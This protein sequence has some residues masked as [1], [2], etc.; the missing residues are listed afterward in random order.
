ML[1][2]SLLLLIFLSDNLRAEDPFQ[3]SQRDQQF[4]LS[5]S[6]KSLDPVDLDGF[7]SELSHP[8]TASFGKKLFFDRRLS[9]NGAIACGSCHIP[10]N[11]F[12]DRLPQG[13]G[14]GQT[15]RNTPSVLLAKYSPWQTWDGR[16]DSLWSQALEPLE[17]PLEHGTS[18]QQV[19]EVIKT[20]YLDTY[21]SIFG[22]IEDSERGVDRAFAN[23]G[24]ALMAYQFRLEIKPS[25]FDKFV[26]AVA[27]N[28][29]KTVKQIFSKDEVLGL[30]LFVGK[31]NCISCHNG[32]L[33]TNFEFHNTGVPPRNKEKVDLGR[34]Q[35]VQKLMV[36]EFTCLS[37][38][39][40]L[41]RQS[42]LEMQFL[43]TTGAEL[44]GAFKTPSLRNIAMTAPYM[45]S[46]QFDTLEAVLDHYNKPKPPF[47]DRK[48][49][50]NRPHFDIMPLDLS[51]EE[52]NQ[53]IH[54]LRTLT[55]PP[56]A[57]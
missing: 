17:S 21:T 15:N 9:G 6:L 41:N 56:P 45:H 49:H 37:V 11:Y 34:F 18:R 28:D 20:H 36:D 3:F 35:G 5:L 4:L 55:S 31:A 42:C 44:V 32:P 38:H 23:V 1:F 57:V 52:K 25:R 48:Q 14:I 13:Q 40:G 16:K 33:F 24:K 46:G 29:K 26:E 51:E 54:F 8:K 53:I 50:P 22:A 12:T 19:V 39:S 47:Y 43:K 10:E 30:R 2:V 27:G 7:G